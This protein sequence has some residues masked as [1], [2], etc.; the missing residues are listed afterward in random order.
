MCVSKNLH[1]HEFIFHDFFQETQLPTESTVYM[2]K[3]IYT[4]FNR[5]IY[6][7]DNLN[8]DSFPVV[9]LEFFITFP[10]QNCQS[11]EN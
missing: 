9:P 5:Y 6:L 2:W 4:V 11:G 1:L 3:D 8:S 10:N 7:G